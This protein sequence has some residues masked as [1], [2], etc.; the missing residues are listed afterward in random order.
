M[1]YLDAFFRLGCFTF[2][3]VI[4]MA[5]NKTNAA[6]ILQYYIRRG[7]VVQI[8]KGLYSAINP[9]DKAPIATR[10]LIGSRVTESAVISHHSAFEYYGLINQ[11]SYEVSVSSETKFNTFDFDGYTYFRMPANITIGVEQTM[12]G[13][14][15]TDIERTVLDGINDFE[16]TMGFEELIQCISVVPALREDKLTSY[17]NA[18]DKMFLYQ[19]TGFILEKVRDGLDLSDD[20]FDFC[21]SKIH[22]SSR[23]LFSENK[24]LDMEHNNKWRL[25]YPKNLWN[26]ILEGNLDADI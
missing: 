20:F 3:D 10:Y 4:D 8:R 7:T 1:K 24:H 17:L 15:I 23:Y 25:T 9:V 11:V 22:H 13:E 21:K 12:D 19:K 5:G 18:Y 26:T 14:K 2:A 6:S 16:K